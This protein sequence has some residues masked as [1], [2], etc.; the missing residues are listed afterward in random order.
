MVNSGEELRITMPTVG[1]GEYES[2]PNIS[3][4]AVTFLDMTTI[5]NQSP[6][7]DIQLFRFKAV[8]SGQALITFHNSSPDL[9][10]DVVDTVVVR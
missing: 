2:P 3:G 7:G 10:P 9:H 5:N 8:A 1:P 4:S 6:G